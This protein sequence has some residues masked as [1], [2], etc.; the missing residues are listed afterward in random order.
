VALIEPCF[1]NISHIFNRHAVASTPIPEAILI[2][3]GSVDLSVLRNASALFLVSPNNPTGVAYS[4][5]NFQLLVNKCESLGLL[6][7]VDASFRFYSEDSQRFDEYEI[8]LKSDVQ[9]IIIEDT[10]KTWP[11]Q[12]IK[13]S[14]LASR[15]SFGRELYDIYTDFILHVSPFALALLSAFIKG[16]I[17]DKLNI[18]TN[19]VRRNKSALISALLNSPLR[20]SNMALSSVA[21]IQV[22]DPYENQKILKLLAEHAV[23]VLPG[24]QF[25]WSEPHKGGQFIRIALSRDSEVFDAAALRIKEACKKL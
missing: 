10:G 22:S 4:R 12:E 2:D 9:F 18:V 8:L 13:L 11:T 21:W 3:S 20:I 23:Y 16:S 19:V 17:D 15:C 6:L 24:N 5:E 7:I 25:F 1:D 14:I